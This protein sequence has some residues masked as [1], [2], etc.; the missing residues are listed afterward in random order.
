MLKQIF[1]SILYQNLPIN[2]LKC[3]IKN[4][5][6]GAFPR[7]PLNYNLPLFL[8]KKIFLEYFKVKI[9][10]RFTPKPPNFTI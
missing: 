9:L 7:K 10:P 4:I 8:H 1:R 6:G 3:I 2:V 5:R